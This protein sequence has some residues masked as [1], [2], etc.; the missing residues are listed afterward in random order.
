MKKLFATLLALVMIFTMSATAF[1]IGEET[2]TLTI[3]GATGH[4]YKVYQIF[5]GDISTEGDKTVLSNVLYGANYGV[6]GTAVEPSL[7]DELSKSQ[8]L[9]T[10]LK[11]SLHGTPATITPENGG[12]VIEVTGLVAGYY[13]VVDV[14]S[15]SQMPD[16]QTKSPV[17]LQIVESVSIASKHASIVSTKKV[18]DKNDST[19]TED[20]IN[21]QD[22][23]DYDIG[24]AVPFQL[25]V[26]LPTTLTGHTSYELTIHDKQAI[27]FDT[28]VISAVYI[29]KADNTTKIE[30][31]AA[32]TGTHGYTLSTNCSKPTTCEYK[33]EGGCTFNIH[34]GDIIA[35]Y[36]QNTFADGD[37]L[38]V[39]YSAVLNNRA[40]VGA[41]GSVNSMY[42]CHPDGHTP[43]DAVT[44]LTYALTVNKIDGANKEALNGAGFTLEKLNAATGKYEPVKV[45]ENANGDAIY[46]LKGVAMTSFVWNGIDGGQYRLVE[47]TTPAGYNTIAPIEFVVDAT[48]K[49]EWLA[50]G[51]NAFEDLIAKNLAGD[52][53]VFAD[54]HEGVED[55]KL[56]GNV[57]NY[58]GTILPETGAEGTFFMIA[59][60][61]MLVM[62]A[63]VFMVTRKKMSIYED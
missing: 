12:S 18:D 54:K 46:E 17:I 50:D 47:T 26:T 11:D 32:T 40:N 16:G 44:V 30:I 52:T 13:M 7:L 21:W 61:A 51:N 10:I 55:G 35:L 36:G 23:A 14:T 22:A 31:P 27:G 5:T 63:A 25:T 45:G 1:A 37:M 24:D 42:V 48:H 60:G 34:V 53:V 58:K 2:Y 57:E 38:V 56:E 15:D 3:T 29:L 9:A 39:E 6:T 41:E 59:G 4:S 62:V 28:P 33:E 19:T 20:E 49:T 43:K 8:N